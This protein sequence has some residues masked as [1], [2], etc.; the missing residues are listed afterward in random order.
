MS[1]QPEKPLI[2]IALC[3][4]NGE[5]FLREQLDSLINQSY[6]RKEIIAV[7]DNSTDSSCEIL[8]EYQQQ[9]PFIHFYKNEVNIGYTK[10]FE[11]ALHLC[12]GTY[13]A[14][15]DQDDIWHPDKL[16][17]LLGEIANHQ[18]IYHDSKFID[19]GGLSLNKKMSDVINLYAGGKSE[20]FLLFNCVSGHSCLFKKELLKHILPLDPA[21]FHDHW[22]AY[23]ATN[24]GTIHCV[25]ECLVS[26]RQH[27]SNSTDILNYRSI[28]N[29]HYHENRDIQK[30]E[31]DL[32]WIK[33]CA[34][35]PLN[36]NPAFVEHLAELF[37]TRLHSYLSIN[38]ARFIREH[39]ETLYFIQRIRK[40]KR[41][42]FIYRQM[43]GLR[44]KLL[45]SRV[46]GKS[47]QYY[48]QALDSATEFCL[49]GRSSVL[50]C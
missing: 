48:E 46:F 42:S 50:L 9:Y 19:E 39:F 6:E 41:N 37:E 14:L 38:Y 32:R 2:S 35:F 47:M 43:W 15:S 31:R 5:R 12:T 1:K 23:V 7:D 21:Y 45:W 8:F 33:H 40:S 34:S 4:Y 17:C 44:S 24:L 26:Y 28:I 36:K 30:L 18:L 16:Q 10:N 11:K 22:I 49:G 3:V 20:V 29:K 27:A 25:R 13:I